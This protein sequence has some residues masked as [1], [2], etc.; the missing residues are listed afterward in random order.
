[1]R[2]FNILHQQEIQ[3]D[4]E[5]SGP[6]KLSKWE[7]MDKEHKMGKYFCQKFILEKIFREM[8]VI[9]V[10]LIRSSR[11]TNENWTPQVKNKAKKTCET[12]IVFMTVVIWRFFL[13]V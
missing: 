6:F 12:A 11:V 9:N 1:M 7:V 13:Q 8:V 5:N 2:V 10:T 4:S 3:A